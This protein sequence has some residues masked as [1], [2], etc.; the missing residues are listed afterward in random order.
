MKRATLF[1]RQRITQFAQSALLAAPPPL[2]MLLSTAV[3]FAQLPATQF[4]SIYP[5]GAKQGAKVEVTIAGADLDDADKLLILNGYKDT[6]YVETA[7]AAIEDAG[8]TI[9]HDDLE[10]R[11]LRARGQT[12]NAPREVVAQVSYGTAA[13]RELA[14]GVFIQG[15]FPLQQCKGIIAR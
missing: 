3:A 10:R 15:Q 5:P 6:E 9:D 13:K 2:A 1:R 7:L 8:L 14:A 12:L 4:T 11:V